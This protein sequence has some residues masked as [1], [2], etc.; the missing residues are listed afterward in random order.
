MAEESEPHVEQQRASVSRD[1]G[2]VGGYTRKKPTIRV[3]GHGQCEYRSPVKP[4]GRHPYHRV[5]HFKVIFFPLL[6]FIASRP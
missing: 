4:E 2:P 5:N 6:F 3:T 1:Q